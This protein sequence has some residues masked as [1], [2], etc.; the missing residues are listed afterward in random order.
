MASLLDLAQARLGGLLVP[1]RPSMAGLLGGRQQIGTLAGALQGYTPPQ[2]TAMTNPQVMDYARNV[3]Q[4]AQQNLQTQMSD[5]DKALV[6]DQGGINVGDRQ[7]LARLLEQVPGLMGATAYHGSPYRFDKF[8]PTKVGAG[9]GAQ[10]Y[11][12]GMY[13]AEHPAVAM[14]YSKI[15]PSGMSATPNRQLFGKDVEPMT[16]EYKVSQL[17]DEMGVAKAKKFIADWAKDPLPDQVGYVDNLQ[18]IISKVSKKSDA[19]NLGA[20]NL[21]KVD[22]PDEKIPKMLNWDIPLSEQSKAVQD[23]AWKYKDALKNQ[24]EMKGLKNIWELDGADLYGVMQRYKM[25]D[26]GKLV[27]QNV[28]IKDVSD[29]M[30]KSD[31]PG[32]R[33]MNYQGKTSE[34]ANTSNFVVFD[35]TD[36]KILERN[37]KTIEGLLD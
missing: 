33:Y 25:E 3:A 29:I 7:A 23:I 11:G 2:M 21:Y 19:K 14:P 32:I 5:L 1:Q 26:S 4:S 31:I 9:E 18:S 28:D 15:V 8:D 20:S 22:I 30:N 13:F 36:V 16:P 12:H 34:G 37:K 17:V 6:M 24:T 10:V 35:P 27:K